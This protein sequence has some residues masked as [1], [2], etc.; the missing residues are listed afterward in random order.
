MEVINGSLWAAHDNPRPVARRIVKMAETKG[1]PLCYWNERWFH[2]NGSYYQQL[3]KERFRDNLYDI[4]ENAEYMGKDKPLKWKPNPRKLDAVIDAARGLAKLPEDDERKAPCWL[5]GH[6]EPVIACRNCLVRLSDGEKLEH[7]ADYFNLMALPFDYEPNLPVSQRWLEFLDQVFNGDQDVISTLQLWF[8]Y[9]LTGRTD[10]EQALFLFGPGRSGKGT[11]VHVLQALVGMAACAALSGKQFQGSTFAYEPL[12]GKSLAVLSDDRVRFGKELVEAFLKITGRDLASINRK[13]KVGISDYIAARIV[14]LSNV[15]LGLPDDTGAIR[16]RLIVLHTPNVY[17]KD[18]AAGTKVADVKLKDR[19]VQEE[20]PGVLLWALE[21][22]RKLDGKI[23][24]PASSAKYRD[25][26]TESGSPITVFLHELFE[27]GDDDKTVSDDKRYWIPKVDAYAV[28]R[29]WCDVNGHESGSVDNL[30]RK[31]IESMPTVAPGVK[32]EWKDVKRGP[33]GEQQPAYAGLRL[34]SDGS[35]I[36]SA[37]A[38]RV[39][40]RVA[41]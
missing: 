29:S 22:A 40:L 7:T 15:F 2:W 10:L 39:T 38:G 1:Q 16:E 28:W 41:K 17:T 35:Q 31:L 34:N 14:F 33:R 21:G 4:L 30:K 36:L 3:T 5:D 23:P 26:I 24:Q 27:F 6:D 9:V 12:M 19:L 13:N 8:G 18:G 25:A 20:L 37:A 32:F 11:I